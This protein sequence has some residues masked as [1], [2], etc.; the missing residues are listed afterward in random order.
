MAADYS[1]ESSLVMAYI[2]QLITLILP[3]LNYKLRYKFSNFD[4]PMQN[5]CIMILT[6]CKNVINSPLEFALKEKQ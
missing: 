6:L 2:L 1:D 3:M 5:T 4:L